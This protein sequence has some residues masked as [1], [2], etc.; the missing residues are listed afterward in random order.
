MLQA[1]IKNFYYAKEWQK[2]LKSFTFIKINPYKKWQN[3]SE[4]FTFTDINT[5]PS[6]CFIN[7][8]NKTLALSK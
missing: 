4:V 3:N 8:Q 7:F 5:L 6:K 2:N 1:T